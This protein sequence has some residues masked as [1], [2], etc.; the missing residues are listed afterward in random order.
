[1]SMI[2][3][4]FGVTREGTPIDRYTLRNS[5]GMQAD[6]ITFGAV[7]NRLMVPDAAGN[8]ADVT[9]GYDDLDGYEKVG[10]FLG[11][12]VGRY[13]NRIGGASFDLDGKTYRLAA[14]D[15][16]NH[17][18]GGPKGYAAVVWS[19]RVE[20][21]DGQDTLVLSYDS[22]DGEEGYPGNLQAQVSYSLSEN[23]ELRLDYRAVSD[24]PTI[25]NLTNH[26]Y[27]N[28]SGHDAGS[29]LDHHIRIAAD[30]FTVTDRESIPT[31]EIRLVAGT[32][33]D[34]RKPTRVG[35]DIDSDYDQLRFPG[36]YDNN[37]VLP[38]D[39]KAMLLAAEV[40]DPASGRVLQVLT[41]QRGIQFYAGNMLQ[42][43]IPG[44]GGAKYVRR[45]GFCL[46]TQFYPDSIHFPHFPTP[47]IRPGE[48]QE[49]TTVFRFL[50]K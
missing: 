6:I 16:R 50:A 33:L 47:V 12:V 5:H 21:R 13:A 1:M 3:S 27:F 20:V 41:N 23:N 39:G 42:L 14:N 35:D 28:L 34:L 30:F 8:L 31:G 46:E 49:S 32:P 15:G 11:A 2:K 38:S 17:L 22:P 40:S 36:G 18:H 48:V 10:P 9:L 44:K 24:T 7:L 37:W 4:A 19:A 45:G 25:A 26:A 43:D 29:I